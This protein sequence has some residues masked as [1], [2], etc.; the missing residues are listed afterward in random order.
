MLHHLMGNKKKKKRNNFIAADG[1][2]LSH[3]WLLGAKYMKR[4]GRTESA[5]LDPLAGGEE[6][7]RVADYTRRA[8]L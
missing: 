5:I 2:L 1:T 7:G 8:H 6:G 3:D 4:R